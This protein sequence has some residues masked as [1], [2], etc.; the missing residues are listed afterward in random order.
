MKEASSNMG[1][2]F[3][4]ENLNI[5]NLRYQISLSQRENSFVKT[6]LNNKQHITKKFS[7]IK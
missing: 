1:S 3:S 4:E 5:E 6:E 2:S 7:N